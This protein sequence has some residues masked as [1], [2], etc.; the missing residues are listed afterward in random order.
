[1]KLN[2]PAAVY[3]FESTML[4]LFSP[5]ILVSHSKKHVPEDHYIDEG[6][7]YTVSDLLSKAFKKGI[8]K[9]A[10]NIHL[11]SAVRDYVPPGG[12]SLATSYHPKGQAVDIH[13]D[14]VDLKALTA[15]IMANP[16]DYDALGGIGIYST[17]IH[18]DSRTV[19]GSHPIYGKYFAFW[20][21][22]MKPYGMGTT[23]DNTEGMDEVAGNTPWGVYVAIGA[24]ITLLYFA[25]KKKR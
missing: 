8:L 4:P 21:D 10:G 1:M 16:A 20:T 7:L 5:E 19:P 12:A 9:R 13:F 2:E 3:P 6:L 17:W 14:D 15:D 25:L 18:F 22:G 23:A 24:A 11:T